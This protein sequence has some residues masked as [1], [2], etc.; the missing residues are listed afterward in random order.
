MTFYKDKYVL[1]S[2]L[3]MMLSAPILAQTCK[4]FVIVIPSYNNARWYERNL[5][6]V[7]SQNYTDF[8]VIYV[9]DC[10][11]DSTGDLVEAY[12]EKNDADHKVHL[13]KNSN[14]RGPLHN[15]YTMIYMSD[16]DE[17]IVTLDGD[18]WLPDNDVLTRLNEV[19]SSD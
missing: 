13:I 7:L 4:K 16:D 1:I 15:L 3:L 5:Q 6:S 14:R 2:T 8:R 19:Y 10:S 12:L 9:D 17:I 18:D 11:P